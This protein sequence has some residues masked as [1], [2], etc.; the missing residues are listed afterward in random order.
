MLEKRVYRIRNRVIKAADIRNASTVFIDIYKKLLKKHNEDIQSKAI[1]QY[2]HQPSI[3][4]SIDT[5]DNANYSSDNPDNPEL[6]NAN[7]ILDTKVITGFTYYISYYQESLDVTLSLSDSRYGGHSG[8]ITVQGTDN[9]WVSATFQKLQDCITLWESQKSQIKRYRWFFSPILLLMTGWI[10][11]TIIYYLVLL[12]QPNLSDNG[13]WLI[14]LLVG[15]WLAMSISLPIGN[16][17][18]NLWPDIEFIPVPEQERVLTKKRA[19]LGWIFSV[20]VVP[21]VISIILELIFRH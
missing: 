19:Q 4:F 17:I 7:G 11:G 13:S 16:Y 5:N 6:F 12:F 21:F 15:L 10:L 3:K 18:D 9:D 20:I 14:P 2:T 8:T 1:S